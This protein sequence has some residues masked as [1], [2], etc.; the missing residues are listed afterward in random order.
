MAFP[1]A[2]TVRRRERRRG[3]H[4]CLR[5]SG[6]SHK[7][8]VLEQ[9]AI[10]LVPNLG[11]VSHGSF[12]IRDKLEAILRRWSKR[13]FG[14]R[15]RHRHRDWS[16]H[17]LDKISPKSLAIA[18]RQSLAYAGPVNAERLEHPAYQSQRMQR[19]QAARHGERIEHLAYIMKMKSRLAFL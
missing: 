8:L 12:C 7:P 6:F 4:E 14:R 3:P 9:R 11:E 5:H 2:G 1:T 18:E 13:R 17:T 19:V 15:C 10:V 16:G